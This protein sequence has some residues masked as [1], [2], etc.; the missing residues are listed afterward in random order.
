M[1]GAVAS[2]LLYFRHHQLEHCGLRS[3]GVLGLLNPRLRLLD[4]GI[5]FLEL[6]LRLE[7]LDM[8]RVLGLLPGQLLA[9]SLHGKPR[10]LSFLQRAQK[11]AHVRK[12]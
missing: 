7:A 6:G 3:L 12:Y 8:E 5:S 10:G 1:G 4:L 9:L 11:G 2:L